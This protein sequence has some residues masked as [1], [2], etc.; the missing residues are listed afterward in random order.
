MM[1][2]HGQPVLHLQV[3]A[4]ERERVRHENHPVF[5][6]DIATSG[7]YG[8][9]MDERHGWIKVAKH[10]SGYTYKSP[11]PSPLSPSMDGGNGDVR[12]GRTR[13]STPR[14]VVDDPQ[15]TVPLE[16]LLDVRAFIQRFFPAWSRYPIAST[17]I[18]WYCDSWDGNF[19][20]DQVPGRP[21]VMVAA[22][23][24][25]H[26]FKVCMVAACVWAVC[27]VCVCVCVCNVRSYSLACG[28][29]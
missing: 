20:I 25:G 12:D 10:S 13:P 6:V 16:F 22:G 4:E 17:R 28:T 18:C 15:Q 27:V 8:F 26:G 9:P 29:H 11:S 23:G 7:Y 24:S 3:P 2:A 14:T 1:E 21:G 19:Y 5:A